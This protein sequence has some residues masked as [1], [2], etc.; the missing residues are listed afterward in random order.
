VRGAITNYKAAHDGAPPAAF[1]DL[2]DGDEPALD[3]LDNDPWGNELEL[4]LTNGD[5]PNA[6][7]VCLGADGAE[8][9][10]GVNADMSSDD[11]SGELAF[12]KTF[13][14]TEAYNKRVTEGKELAQKMTERF[15]P[16]YYVISDESF[17]KL[18]KTRDELV[19]DPDA[20][21][22]DEAGPGP[23]GPPG[24]PFPPPGG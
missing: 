8:G 9:G 11:F 1:A 4:R 24:G 10:E 17:K 23:M 3:K 12:Q 15:A 13:D 2:L 20:E 21:D 18:K 16:W 7:V 6:I 5:A 14:D 22:E 19:K